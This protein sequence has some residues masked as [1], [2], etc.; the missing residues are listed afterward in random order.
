MGLS[1]GREGEDGRILDAGIRGADKPQ[2]CV[3]VLC[4]L[5]RFWLGRIAGNMVDGWIVQICFKSRVSELDWD[6]SFMMFVSRWPGVG[7]VGLLTTMDRSEKQWAC[8]LPPIW[9]LSSWNRG[10]CVV[11]YSN[12]ALGALE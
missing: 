4:L 8:F 6:D 2:D 5:A 9:L 11:I 1:T 12:S 3:I 10:E 7:V